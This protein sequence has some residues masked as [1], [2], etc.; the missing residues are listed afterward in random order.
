MKGIELFVGS[1]SLTKIARNR[2]HK[3]FTVDIEQ[4]GQTDLIKDIEFLKLKDLPYIPDFWWVGFPCT[5]YSI[6]GIRHHRINKKPISDFALKSDRM[7][8]N[9]INLIKQTPNSIFYIENPRGVLRKMDFMQKFDRTTVTYCSYGDIRM[10][11]T[12]IFTNNLKSLFNPNGWNPLPMCWNNNK[13]C[14][15]EPSPRGQTVRKAKSKGLFLFKG[16]TEKLKNNYERSKM[17]YLLCEEIIKAT[18]KKII[19]N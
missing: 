19:N 12:D 9:V 4:Y 15:H 14:H 7:M 16:G 10:K 8:L 18:E 13:K 6:A 1:G 2:G 17:P 3:M 5:S 11:P